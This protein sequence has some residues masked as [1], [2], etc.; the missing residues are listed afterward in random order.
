MFAIDLDRGHTSKRE[1]SIAS[2]LSSRSPSPELRYIEPGQLFPTTALELEKDQEGDIPYIRSPSFSPT[3]PDRVLISGEHHN[4]NSEDGRWAKLHDLA[5][6]SLTTAAAADTAQEATQCN[7]PSMYP[8]PSTVGAPN[9]AGP[10]V[11]KPLKPGLPLQPPHSKATKIIPLRVSTVGKCLQKTR[12]EPGLSIPLA[13]LST[14]DFLS[15][16]PLGAV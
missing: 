1:S 4:P 7:K 16:I 6:T 11:M 8:T 10:E 9:P 5:N 15:L 14:S 12:T 13:T 3:F 2:T